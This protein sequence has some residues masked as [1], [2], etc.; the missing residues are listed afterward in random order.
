MQPNLKRTAARVHVTDISEL[1]N[2]PVK[3][4][5]TMIIRR[6]AKD[7]S[8]QNAQV[9]NIEVKKRG[10]LGINGKSFKLVVEL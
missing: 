3:Q 9:K 8:P 2:E 1:D 5:A 4:A 7:A 10:Y 6:K